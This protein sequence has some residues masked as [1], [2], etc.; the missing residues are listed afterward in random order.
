MTTGSDISSADYVAIQNKAELLLGTGSG[1]R[2]YGQTVQSSDVFSGNAI[3]KAQWDALRFDIVNIK[4]HQDGELPNIVVVNVGDLI[5]YGAGSPNTNYDTILESAIINRFNLSP[6]QAALSTIDTSTRTLPWSTSASCELTATFSTATQAR[7]FFNSGGQ[8]RTSFSLTGGSNTSQV[9]AWV[10]VLNS[11]GTQSFGAVTSTSV[12]YYNL[13]NSYQTYFQRALSTPY[14]ANNVRLEAKTNVSN[15]SSGTAT[16]LNIR[17]TLT[18]GYV[19][20][21]ATPPPDQVNGT[22]AITL[23]ELKAS[24]SLIPTGTFSIVSPTYSLSPITAS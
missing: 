8:I 17:I 16:V 7:H 12:N 10:N 19:D 5:G 13:T 15:N 22:L 14:S 6:S 2:G 20:S 9:S 4:Y 3:T 24:G 18:D 1:S 23:Q 21:G 11:V